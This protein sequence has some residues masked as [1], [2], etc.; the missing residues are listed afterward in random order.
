MKKEKKE[1]YY[2]ILACLPKYKGYLNLSTRPTSKHNRGEIFFGCKNSNTYQIEFTP[3]E[4]DQ[5][6]YLIQ[7][8]I[9]TGNLI[10]VE[11]QA[12]NKALMKEYEDNE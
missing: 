10:K 8:L 4:I 12:H 1:K 3:S 6:S 7:D 2:L 11:V 9:K 5:F